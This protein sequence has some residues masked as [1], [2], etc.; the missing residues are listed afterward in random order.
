MQLEWSR[1]VLPSKASEAG[2]RPAWAWSQR[3][4]ISAPPQKKGLDNSRRRHTTE[5]MKAIH[6]QFP[7]PYEAP[8]GKFSLLV[9]RFVGALFILAVCLVTCSCR[10]IEPVSANAAGPLQ[11]T[12]TKFADA[13]PDDYGPLIGLTQNPTDPGWV[14]LWFQKPDRTITA[15]FVQI[16]QGRIY[17]KTLTIPRK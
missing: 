17:E 11:F 16:S 2:R 1:M 15:V 5:S 7:V 9:R 10:K 13:I 6:K 14:G 12:P 8:R 4:G 3:V